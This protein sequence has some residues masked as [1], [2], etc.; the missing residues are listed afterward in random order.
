MEVTMFDMALEAETAVVIAL[1]EAVLRASPTLVL[2]ESNIESVM[3]SV[4][5][6][7]RNMCPTEIAEAQMELN[8]LFS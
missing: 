7:K 1:V 5:L 4:A 2:T 8:T 3:M 6:F